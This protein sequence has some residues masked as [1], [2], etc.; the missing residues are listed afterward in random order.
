MSDNKD[1]L[2]KKLY[3][4]DIERKALVY[5]HAPE[6]SVESMVEDMVKIAAKAE[7]PIETEF[8]WA[9]HKTRFQIKPGMT[10]DEGMDVA[11][12]VL[13]T[14]RKFMEAHKKSLKNSK[15]MTDEIRL[16]ILTSETPH[17][18]DVDKN[19]KE[20]DSFI[21]SSPRFQDCVAE[22]TEEFASILD[23]LKKSAKISSLKD[24]L[25]LQS[26]KDNP[27]MR[28]YSD[29]LAEEKGTDYNS[30]S[31]VTLGNVCKEFYRRYKDNMESF[32]GKEEFEAL[33]KIAKENEEF[34][35]VTM[36]RVDNPKHGDYICTTANEYAPAY[37]SS[38]S[39]ALSFAKGLCKAEIKKGDRVLL[40]KNI[41]DDLELG[42]LVKE[43]AFM[44]ENGKYKHFYQAYY[45]NKEGELTYADIIDTTKAMQHK[46]QDGAKRDGIER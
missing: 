24:K 28:Y 23:N 36:E 14:K 33:K 15:K 22:H 34:G 19:C 16:G 39:K 30:V 35:C 31:A 9:L 2:D 8:E 12:K 6:A 1:N 7:L 20:V 3:L 11:E 40:T 4:Y 27:Y 46:T 32:L 26:E 44:Y 25:S 42:K 13:T 21:V 37:N 29:V 10:F 41:V 17:P 45:P 5:E 38:I 18:V 43:D